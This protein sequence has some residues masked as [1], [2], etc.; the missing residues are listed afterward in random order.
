MKRDRA[1]RGQTRK[2]N[3]KGA[4]CRHWHA[5]HRAVHVITVE[6]GRNVSRTHWDKVSA[7]G[8]HPGA[9]KVYANA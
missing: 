3:P 7:L 2:R 9:V 4:N 8:P 5:T 1:I 6:N